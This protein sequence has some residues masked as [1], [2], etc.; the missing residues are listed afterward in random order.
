[1]LY[2]VGLSLLLF[3]LGVLGAL[4]DASS[5]GENVPTPGANFQP[6]RQLLEKARSANGDLYSALQSFVCNEE[7]AR[8]KGDL[9]GA[10]AHVVD[11][12]ST[13]LSF[14]NGVEHYSDILQN[15][16]SRPALS[17]IE[18]AWSEGEFGTLLQ[19]TEKLLETQPVS[20][21]SFTTLRGSPA[22]V[23]NFDVTEEQSPW[24]L[25]VGARHYHIAFSTDVWISIASGEILKI[26]R[27]SMA[28]APETRI[29]EIDWD[30]T[31]EAVNLNGA[32]WL[33]PIEADYSVL[34]A[35]SKRREWNQMSFSNYRRYGSE[36]QLRF[37]G[38]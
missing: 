36:S 5:S 16:R 28:I 31:L 1:M 8:F 21:V 26:A 23:Y 25:E 18:G 22:A 30:V 7:I 37:V 24:D 9:S 27:K 10:K 6:E 2:R 19:Q 11:H 12:V 33:L 38:F 14:E 32:T 4:P 15:T 34:Y 17:D 3:R 35:E 20:F 29:S 13:K